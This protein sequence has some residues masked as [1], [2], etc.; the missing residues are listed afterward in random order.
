VVGVSTVDA[1]FFRFFFA[2]VDEV[3]L[4]LLLVLLLLLIRS[5]FFLQ[6]VHE[7]VHTASSVSTAALDDASSVST[8]LSLL[9]F[10]FTVRASY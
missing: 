3:L 10:C 2:A 9:L 1:V 6:A 5:R 8:V 7:H 4:L